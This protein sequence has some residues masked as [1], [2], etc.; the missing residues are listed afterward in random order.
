MYKLL[1]ILKKLNASSSLINSGEQNMIIM[2]HDH[3][4]H[5]VLSLLGRIEG[6]RSTNFGLACVNPRC[7]RII[8][9]L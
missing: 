1:G 4:G 6:V 3:L 5:V 8:H 2:A 9:P 7:H